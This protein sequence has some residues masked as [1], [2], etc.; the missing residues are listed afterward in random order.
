MRRN[1]HVMNSLRSQIR[2]FKG[3]PGLPGGVLPRAPNPG[4]YHY[5]RWMSGNPT[6][7]LETARLQFDHSRMIHDGQHTRIR[8]PTQSGEPCEVIPVQIGSYTMFYLCCEGHCAPMPIVVRMPNVSVGNALD[9]KATRGSAAGCF[10]GVGHNNQLFICCDDSP[11]IPLP[12]AFGPATN[13]L[14]V[15]QHIR[16]AA[17]RLNPDPQT[18]VCPPGSEPCGDAL[19]GHMPPCCQVQTPTQGSSSRSKLT[20]RDRL[21]MSYRL[22]FTSR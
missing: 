4:P 10:V 16:E 3:N 5:G 1:R 7:T 19:P 22:L 6:N 8:V 20:L 18:P 17:H 13:P 12:I 21:R 2:L 11:C 14:P 9:L 15:T